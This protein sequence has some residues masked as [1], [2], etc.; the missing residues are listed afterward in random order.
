MTVI[1]ESISVNDSIEKLYRSNCAD[2]PNVPYLW[3]ENQMLWCM[4]DV[5]V[6]GFIGIP[7][8][9]LYTVTLYILTLNEHKSGDAMFKLGHLLS[10]RHTQKIPLCGT[11]RVERSEMSNID[12]ASLQEYSG[13]C[14]RGR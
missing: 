14:Y 1:H 12:R 3:T 4:A 7:Q 13:Q 8:S 11:L 9:T 6:D 10:T 2:F 5:L